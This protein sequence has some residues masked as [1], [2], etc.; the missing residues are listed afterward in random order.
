[1]HYVSIV[2]ILNKSDFVLINSVDYKQ[3]LLS[4]LQD[5]VELHGRKL[6]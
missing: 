5:K 3:A 2:Q 6:S 1:M 4:L